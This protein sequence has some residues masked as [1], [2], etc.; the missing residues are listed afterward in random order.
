MPK[1]LYEIL[2]VG[3]N[4]TQDEV[5]R[6]YL[7][8]A[9]KYHPDKTGG[10]KAA[11]QKLK[12]V[13]AAY[14]VLKNP[15]K[16]RQYDQFGTTDGQPFGGGG[17]GGFGGGFGDFGSAFDSP[18]EDFFD[19]L[20]GQGGRRRGRSG[21]QAGADLEYRM[22]ITLEE[23]AFGTKK[24]IRFARQETC[25]E[26]KGSGA[27]AGSSPQTCGQCQGSGQVRVAQGFFSVTRPCPECRGAGRVITRPCSNCSGRGQVKTTRE[28]AAEV[29][30]GVDTGSRLRLTG[31]G[32]PGRNGGAR[33]DLYIFVEV[34]PH[35]IFAREGTTILCEA[36]V[37][38][39][40][41]AL[42]ATISVP[43]LD[44]K[45]ELKVPAGT[46][47]GDALRLRGMGMPDLRG[48]R[49][50]DQIVRVLV[51]TPNKLSR[52]QR[53]LLQQLAEMS[54]NRT[55]PK[56]NRFDKYVHREKD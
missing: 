56:R 1:D 32:E 21:A 33:G 52:K 19:V 28:L 37:T 12:E 43:T 45:A 29:P 27:A 25:S 34:E 41:A 36:P 11:E 49:Q 35:E 3:R 4:A 48:Y 8:L 44:G 14:D 50:G 47:S 51:E 16:R 23:A 20:F 10:D 18:F 15:E 2:G 17:A 46:Q 53:E 38:S 40:E 22:N 13:N 24:K 54:E 9:H 31:E 6:A 26:C 55:Y 30:P 39:T 7:K 5:R 42:G